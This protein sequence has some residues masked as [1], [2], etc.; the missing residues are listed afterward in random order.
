[1]KNYRTIVWAL[2]AGLIAMLLSGAQS[3]ALWEEAIRGSRWN[4][5]LLDVPQTA[6]SAQQAWQSAHEWRI[7]G[8][9]E[10][11]EATEDTRAFAEWA[12]AYARRLKKDGF[13]DLPLLFDVPFKTK[14]G[15]LVAYAFDIV[16][17]QVEELFFRFEWVSC[18]PGRKK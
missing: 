5:A 10:K 17:K 13:T 8:A 3:L 18:S 11:F 16:P 4:G 7:A 12:R 1:M 15:L 14:T 9:L 6:A 2:G